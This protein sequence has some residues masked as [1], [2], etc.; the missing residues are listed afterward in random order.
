MYIIRTI[1]FQVI[2]RVKFLGLIATYGIQNK[3][4]LTK[5]NSDPGINYSIGMQSFIITL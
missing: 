1:N 4:L 2:D 3:I 5:A